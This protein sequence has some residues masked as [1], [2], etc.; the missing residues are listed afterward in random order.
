MSDDDVVLSGLPQS[1]AREI[2]GDD[3]GKSALEEDSEIDE[4]MQGHEWR[5]DSSDGLDEI[6]YDE[7]DVDDSGID[8][9]DGL[10]D[11]LDDDEGGKKKGGWR[12][13]VKKNLIYIL[14]A[15]VMGSY[16]LWTKRDV[17]MEQI[18]LGGKTLPPPAPLIVPQAQPLSP[19]RPIPSQGAADR[20]LGAGGSRAPAQMAPQAAAPAPVPRRP[21]NMQ[22]ATPPPSPAPMMQAPG[23][24]QREDVVDLRI[25]LQDANQ[26]IEA[27]KSRL[28]AQE[29]SASEAIRSL[30]ERIARLESELAA[31]KRKSSGKRKA[32]DSASKKASVKSAK[33]KAKPKKAAA[34]TNVSVLGTYMD[35]DGHW[36][37]Q[38]LIG[39]SVYEARAGQKIR[40]LKISRVDGAGAVIN[41]R[42]YP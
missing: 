37:A 32:T 1:M 40:G 36:V 30:Y 29:K 6:G 31:S 12:E 28:D 5:A 35:Q 41:G 14:A 9:P 33:R 34:R 16:A 25:E 42:R 18:G 13:W 27:L 38:I 8:D 24:V 17:I 4:F 20:L 11:D 15:A 22:V 10:A 3:H 19:N 39:S 2:D 23:V 26:Q 7:S 21:A